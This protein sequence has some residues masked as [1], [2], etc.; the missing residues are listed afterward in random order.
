VF[1]E[2]SSFDI[3]VIGQSIS[4]KISPAEIKKCLTFNLFRAKICNNGTQCVNDT[5]WFWIGRGGQ[6]QILLSGHLAAVDRMIS[7][8][9]TTC[10]RLSSFG[11]Q[12]F[13]H[14]QLNQ[15]QN[16]WAFRCLSQPVK[17]KTKP[18]DILIFF[19]SS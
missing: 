13:F 10:M 17:T 2:N 11:S 9:P 1:Q 4:N 19:T 7:D 12:V 3:L 16:N 15:K 5:N 14:F 6:R 18:V 8:V